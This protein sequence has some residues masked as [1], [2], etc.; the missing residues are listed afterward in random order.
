[1]PITLGLAVCLADPVEMVAINNMSKMKAAIQ[2]II[3]KFLLKL[4]ISSVLTAINV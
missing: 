4:G 3:F 2:A 1:M